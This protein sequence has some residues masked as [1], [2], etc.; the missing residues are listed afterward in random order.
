[1]A[2]SNP[3]AEFLAAFNLALGGN[4]ENL[5]YG[6]DIQSGELYTGVANSFVVFWTYDSSLESLVT[7]ASFQST[8]DAQVRA[9][10]GLSVLWGKKI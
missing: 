7:D 4:Q 2:T 8:L 10:P 9:Q 1:M 6:V 3:E 5:I